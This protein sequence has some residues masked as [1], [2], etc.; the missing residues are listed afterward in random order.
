MGLLA[1]IVVTSVIV[2]NFGHC[3]NRAQTE[4][5]LYVRHL[6]LILVNFRTEDDEGQSFQ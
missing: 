6:L 1:T 5:T 2:C 3:K 4:L